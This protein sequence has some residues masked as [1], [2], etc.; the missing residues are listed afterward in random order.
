[1]RDGGCAFPGGSTPPAWADAHHLRH[2]VDGGDTDLDNLVMLCG[3]HHRLMHH[4]D[5]EVELTEH[6]RPQFIPPA[7]VDL[8][9]TPIPGNRPDLVS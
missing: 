9:R 5:W 7:S 3:H 1:M 8:F 4:T 6:L 2:W